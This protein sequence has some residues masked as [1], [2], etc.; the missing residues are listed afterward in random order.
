MAFKNKHLSYSRLSRFEQCPLSFKLHY[1]EKKLA[2]PNDSLRFGKAVHATLEV[3]VQEQMEQERTGILSEERAM[4]LWRQSFVAEG[5]SG[6]E[7][8]QEGVT[9]LKNFIRE[10]GVIDH[11]D[12]LAIEQEFHL[13]VGPFTVLGYI[14]RVDRVDDETVEVIDYKTNRMLFTRDEV[15]ASLQMSL[16]HLA[17]QML[18]PWAKK[19]RLT[20]NMLRHNISMVTERNQEQLE[21][22]KSYVMSMGQQTESATEFPARLNS[23]CIY[24]DHR[25]DCPVYA[26]ALKGK[27]T[28]ICD[29]MMK[30]NDVARER[31]EVA[32]L[33]KV[34]YA[35]KQELEDV[36]KTH[37]KENDD[38]IVG[39]IRYCMFN[40]TKVDHPLSET[41]ALLSRETDM[42]SDEILSRIAVVDKKA[43]DSL[44]KEI[45][46]TKERARVNLL[47]AE[48]DASA[49]KQYSPR[50]WAKEMKA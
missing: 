22:A 40:T 8:F 14:D 46:K 20:F 1:I 38:L 31:E 18:W 3:L 17:A 36:L 37:L 16:Y 6:M 26:E 39:K 42:S 13:P 34:L 15:D 24:C 10:Q 5:M 32:K 2:E 27:R 23:N 48:L 11:Q 49:S 19:V 29:D 30:L 4:E 28:F 12:V 50:F 33:A 25:N 7:L 41:V 35:R 43:L 47:K 45:G 44:L 9:I 21:A